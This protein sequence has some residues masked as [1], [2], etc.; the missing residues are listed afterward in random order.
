MKKSSR[1]FD[2]TRF[3]DAIN[4]IRLENDLSWRDLAKQA[5]I[6]PSAFSRMKRGKLVDTDTMT[7]LC[8][9]ANL[10]LREFSLAE[11]EQGWEFWE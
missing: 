7:W 3:Y 1:H 11:R 5:G 4:A 9:W 2:R 8:C 6:A 10:D